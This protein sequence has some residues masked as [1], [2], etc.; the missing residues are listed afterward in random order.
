MSD[1][2]RVL[3]TVLVDEHARDAAQDRTE[4][5]EI[6]ERLRSEVNRL[7][8]GEDV[9]ERE[10]V[11]RELERTRDNKDDLRAK[12]R[13]FQNELQSLESKE[14][15]LEERLSNFVDDE[16]KYI[17]HLESL[18]SQLYEGA[19]VDSG[20]GGVKRAA[21]VAKCDPEDV[22]DELKERNPEIPEYAFEKALHSDEDWNGVEGE[23]LE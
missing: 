22:I 8:F 7:A 20:H 4:H 9:E 16:Q 15:R 21:N 6:S 13:E 14:T 2:D 3:V 1:D 12:I 17:G 18:E 23:I 5:G 19:N 11:K 10:S